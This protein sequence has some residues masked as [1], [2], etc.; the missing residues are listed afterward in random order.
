MKVVALAMRLKHMKC[1]HISKI[2]WTHYDLE[3]ACAVLE[4]NVQISELQL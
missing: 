3:L 2:F 4:A 1:I